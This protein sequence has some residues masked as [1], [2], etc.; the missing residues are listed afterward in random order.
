VASLSL[1]SKV[2]KIIGKFPYNISF[3]IKDNIVFL[4]GV[5]EKYEE[6][7]EIGLEIGSK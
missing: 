5:V 3:K 6:W 4:E 7:V 1:E 2:K